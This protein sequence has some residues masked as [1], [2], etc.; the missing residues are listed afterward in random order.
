MTH[1]TSKTRGYANGAPFES[2]SA[3]R[4]SRIN[5]ATLM[6]C[7]GSCQE[8]RNARQPTNSP[9]MPLRRWKVIG[10]ARLSCLGATVSSLLFLKTSARQMNA[11]SARTAAQA[12]NALHM[13][14]QKIQSSLHFATGSHNVLSHVCNARIFGS[15]KRHSEVWDY[16]LQPGPCR[17]LLRENL[18]ALPVQYLG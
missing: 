9:R 12:L 5:H 13:N 8:I 18:R 14:Q 2:A 15:L 16:A 10:T 11:E 3:W 1:C 6:P 4:F 17:S 7:Q